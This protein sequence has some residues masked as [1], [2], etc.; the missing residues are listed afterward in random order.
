MDSSFFFGLSTMAYIIA[1]MIYIAYLAFKKTQVGIMATTITIIGF[2]SQT[3]A[4]ILRWKEFADLSGMGFLRSAP[5]TNLYESLIFFVWCLILGYL[6]VEFK[7]KNRS[8]GAF[9]TPKLLSIAE[10]SI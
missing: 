3:T 1:M 7:F 8:F 6:V 5:M 9:I 10:T 4:I 2:L